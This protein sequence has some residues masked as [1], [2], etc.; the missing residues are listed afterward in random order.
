MSTSVNVVQQRIRIWIKRSD[1]HFVDVLETSYS[2]IKSPFPQAVQI[3][4]TVSLLLQMEVC[5]ARFLQ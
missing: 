2:I 4:S 1:R 5:G 3:F